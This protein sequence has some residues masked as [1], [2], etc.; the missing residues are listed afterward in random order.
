MLDDK[1]IYKRFFLTAS[2]VIGLC[3][4]AIFLGLAMRSSALI[5]EQVLLSARSHFQ[6]IVLTRLWS[7][8]HGGVYV[9][10]TPG[11]QSNPYLENPDLK[12]ADGRLLTLKNP[13]L[14]TR[15]ISEL[16]TRE[17]LFTFHITSL[18][19]L[20]PDNSPDPFEVQA[21]RS[22]EAGQK[23][24]TAATAPSAGGERSVFRYMAPLLVEPACLSCHAK[25]G[26]QV[27][28]V[29]GGISVSF[30]I[31]DMN[32]ALRKNEQTILLQGGLT[33]A[34]LLLTLWHF[35]RQMQL[36]LNES[37]ALLLRMATT[38]MLTNVPNRASVMGR[39]SEGFARQRRQS[40]SLGC[41]MIDVDHFKAVND[42]FGHQKGDMVLRELAGILTESLRPY[43]T[44]GR[45]GGEEFLMVLDGVDA[46]RLA[47]VAERSRA[48]IEARLGAQS[49][50]SEPVTISLG[51]TLVIP[52]DRSIDDVIHR[53]DEALYLAKNQ[54]RNRVVMLGLDP[55][56]RPGDSSG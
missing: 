24:A 16:A 15:E 43:D 32:R 47:E 6:G 40:T 20:N 50:L 14:M 36:K 48:L 54:G 5:K 8:K 21:L 52:E 37:Q 3:V 26:Y 51:G 25:Q 13:A 23:E 44:F 30:D 4:S 38:D 55:A 22:F 31:S 49:G 41:L 17:A 10:K 27:G 46:K 45:Y 11:M 33:L 29:R 18:K 12:A 34:L 53:A 39:F 9:I 7:A 56:V 19:P 42:R 2:L 1:Q 28:Q 35:F